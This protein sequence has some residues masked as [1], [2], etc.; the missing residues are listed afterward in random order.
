VPSLTTGG[1]LKGRNVGIHELSEPVQYAYDT[2]A[3]AID[4]HVFN[5]HFTKSATGHHIFNGADID[6][7]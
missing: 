1:V 4:D 7:E 6:G 5:E 3:A 2:A